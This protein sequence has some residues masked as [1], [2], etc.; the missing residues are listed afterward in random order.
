MIGNEYA[1]GDQWAITWADDGYLYAGWGDGTGFGHRG[2]WRDQWSTYMGLARISGDPPDNHTGANVWGGFQPESRKE[3]LYHNVET[4]PV[5]LKPA[6]G[7]IF[8]NGVMY[9]YAKEKMDCLLMSSEDYGK[10]WKNHGAIFQEN[11]KFSYTGVIQFGKNY[12]GVPDSLGDYLYIYDGGGGGTSNPHFDRKDMLLARVPTDS[13]ADRS[14]YQFFNG[15]ASNPSWTSDINK[16]I[17]IFHDDNG[18][19]WLVQCV[20]NPGIDRYILITKNS[21]NVDGEINGPSIDSKGFGIF[22]AKQPWG[23]WR[24]IYYTEKVGNEISGLDLAISFTTTQKW[25]S[26]NGEEMWIVFSGRPSSPMYSFNLIKAKLDVEI[27]TK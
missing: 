6:H 18:V 22:E 20:Y 16:A 2:R 14:S 15:T 5:N 21:Y 23:P 19:N 3:A 9:W 13:L 1:S 8:L 10:T 4:K 12:S 17:P 7:L 24:T 27:Q 11:G 26:R 25:M